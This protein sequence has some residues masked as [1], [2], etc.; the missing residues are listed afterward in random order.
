MPGQFVWGRKKKL[1]FLSLGLHGSSYH[2]QNNRMLHRC[3][4]VLIE[5]RECPEC[6][7]TCGMWHL[8]PLSLLWTARV[9]LGYPSLLDEPPHNKAP[10]SLSSP[11]HFKFI[12]NKVVLITIYPSFSQI[13]T[14][15]TLQPS[16]PFFPFILTTWSSTS[17]TYI[18]CRSQSLAGNSLKTTTRAQSQGWTYAKHMPGGKGALVTL[19]DSQLDRSCAASS[20]SICSEQGMG[21]E[22][23]GGPFH[24]ESI[25]NP[26][27]QGV[28]STT[29][30]MSGAQ[31]RKWPM[32]GKGHE[33]EERPWLSPKRGTTFQ[34]IESQN[35]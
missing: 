13:R 29:Q 34:V 33:Q 10:A 31:P 12:Q 17:S 1:I 5:E 23:S 27:I 11:L 24:P 35:Y 18:L 2:P 3:R 16:S 25:Y 4:A 19:G 21:L 30:K 6:W 20:S 7:A 14:P 9:I 26:L 15:P 22:T 8:S 32:T 28:K